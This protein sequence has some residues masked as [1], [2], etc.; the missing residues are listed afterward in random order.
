[1]FQ[2]KRLIVRPARSLASAVTAVAL[3]TAC[4]ACSS[5]PSEPPETPKTPERPNILLIVIDTLRADS[6]SCYGYDR[7]TSPFL[8]ELAA[9]GVRFDSAYAPSSWTVPSVASMLTSTHVNQHGLG[10]RFRGSDGVTSW[11]VVPTDVP[12]L[13]QSLRE[14]GYRTFGLVANLNLPAERGFGRGFD[15][16]SCIG[17]VDVGPV[18]RALPSWLPE[19]EGTEEPWFFW[20]HLFD[21]HGAYDGRAPWLDQFDPEWEQARHMNGMPPPRFSLNA[22]KFSEREVA[23]AKACYD[24]EIRAADELI[25]EVFEQLPAAD[26]AFVLVTSDHG[27]E[28]LEHGGALHGR[29]L[30]NE[31]IRVPFIVRT[32]DRRAAGTVVTEAVSLV[33]VLPTLLGAAGIEPPPGAVGLNLMRP[34]G[35]HVP[36]GREVFAELRAF[37]AVISA[38]W[39]LIATMGRAD[40][41]K[42]FDLRSD[43]GEQQDLAAADAGRMESKRELVARYEQE[44][45]QAPPE[46]IKID[47]HTLEKLKGL[48][49]IGGGGG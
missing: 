26:A 40:Q 41:D 10:K 16:Y 49:Y 36:E 22:K 42:L 46:Q 25:R 34:D 24:S 8:D 33:D 38:R 13:A 47:R 37:R 48:G 5:E 29:S 28:F 4:G 31:Q 17:S 7:Q 23:V 45:R 30:F 20:L 19:I 11:A 1:M 12:N 27:E 35:A 44:G 6:L 32:P 9:E 39:K 21:P 18:R 14:G 2:G 3:L 15:R 43:P